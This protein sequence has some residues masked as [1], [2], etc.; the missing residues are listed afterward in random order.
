MAVSLSLCLLALRAG[1]ELRRLRQRGARR[2]DALIGRHMK[3]ARPGVLLLCLGFTGGLASA[4]WLRDWRVFSTL[5]AYLASASALLFI[6]AWRLG[7]G[8]AKRRS[9]A[10]DA[11][12]WLGLLAALAAALASMAGFVLLP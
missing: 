3:L 7:V 11:H 1:L 4:I 5:H 8:L 10:V 6:A 2:D 12:G 9:P